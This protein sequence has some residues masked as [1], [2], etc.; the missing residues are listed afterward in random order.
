MVFAA[1]LP[2]AIEPFANVPKNLP[3]SPLTGFGLCLAAIE[4]T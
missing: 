2:F 1:F 3:L 4:L